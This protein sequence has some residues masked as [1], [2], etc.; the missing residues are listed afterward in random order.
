MILFILVSIGAGFSLNTHIRILNDEWT[1]IDF[2][3]KITMYGAIIY[4]GFHFLPLI[5]FFEGK[6]T[7]KFFTSLQDF[8]VCR[9]GLKNSVVPYG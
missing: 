4:M 8:E 1:K 9:S 2:D 3:D 5:A 6:K 7:A